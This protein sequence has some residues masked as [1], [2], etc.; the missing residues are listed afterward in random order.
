MSTFWWWRIHPAPKWKRVGEIELPEWM[1]YLADR[2]TRTDPAVATFP[3]HIEGTVDIEGTVGR[4]A[5]YDS[6][7][8][9]T[10]TKDRGVS[11]LLGAYVEANFKPYERREL[12]YVK[13]PIG[14]MYCLFIRAIGAKAGTARNWLLTPPCYQF[15]DLRS[16]AFE[17]DRFDEWGPPQLFVQPEVQQ[18]T[19][20]ILQG[21]HPGE[22]MDIDIRTA[23]GRVAP[24]VEVALDAFIANW[25][26]DARFLYKAPK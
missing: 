14:G 13:K 9:F 4:R 23:P 6:G 11:D 26:A 22:W 8:I 20:E 1:T 19:G 17:L 15:A 24:Q 18:V 3:G 12:G 21:A 7:R 5:V 25:Q 16:P 2:D 10:R